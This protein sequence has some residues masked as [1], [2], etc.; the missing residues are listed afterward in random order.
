MNTYLSVIGDYVFSITIEPKHNRELEALYA[1][2]NS[3]REIRVERITEL[4]YRKAKFSVKLEE[5]PKRAKQLA[6]KFLEYFGP[7]RM[8]PERKL[9]NL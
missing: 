3:A 8:F 4:L 1:S 6:R 9:A 2:M 5:N 7:E